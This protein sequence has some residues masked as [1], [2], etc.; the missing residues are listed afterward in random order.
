[1]SKIEFVLGVFISQNLLGFEPDIESRFRGP[2]P[3]KSTL[4]KLSYDLLRIS[5]ICYS[6]YHSSKSH[7]VSSTLFFYSL[8]YFIYDPAKQSNSMSFNHDF[9][10]EASDFLVFIVYAFYDYDKNCELSS[11]SALNSFSL[12]SFMSS[13][14]FLIEKS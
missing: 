8:S 7:S 9:T 1:M 11:F 3:L 14:N 2:E 13:V 6:S 4:S 10:G 12:S 5:L